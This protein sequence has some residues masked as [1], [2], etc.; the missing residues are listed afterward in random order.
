MVEGDIDVGSAKVVGAVSGGA[1][2]VDVPEIETTESVVV[3]L[4]DVVVTDAEVAES[5][6]ETEIEV[7]ESVEVDA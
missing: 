5:V 6:V 1:E 4:A 2:V 3:L 7:A